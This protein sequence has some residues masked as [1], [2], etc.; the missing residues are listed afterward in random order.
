MGYTNYY[1]QS[2]DF[3]DKEWNQVKDEFEYIK[4]IAGDAIDVQSEKNS[5]WI[6]FNGNPGC[7]SFYIY[8]YAKTERD[9]KDQDLTFH[10]CKKR[11]LPYDIYVWHMLVF[12][13]GL[14]RTNEKKDFK[15]GRDIYTTKE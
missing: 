7:E 9:Y 1:N 12:I 4:G 5:D 15:I 10:F 13:L 14:K 6:S 3:T 8:K 2:A 11:E